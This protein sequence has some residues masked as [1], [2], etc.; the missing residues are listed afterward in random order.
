LDSS[1]RRRISAQEKDSQVA[2]LTSPFE[3][4]TSLW[5]RVH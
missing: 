4:P 5:P 2:M 3:S 1:L